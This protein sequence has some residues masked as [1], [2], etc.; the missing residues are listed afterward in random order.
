MLEGRNTNVVP[1]S[2]R[3]EKIVVSG[4]AEQGC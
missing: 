2:E 3:L 1:R 4:D